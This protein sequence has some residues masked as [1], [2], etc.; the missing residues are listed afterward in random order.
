MDENFKLF[1][2]ALPAQAPRTYPSPSQLAQ[3]EGKL[4]RRL[5]DY[6]AEHGWGAFGRG[7]FWLVNPADYADLLQ[8]WCDNLVNTEDAYVIGRSAFG[9]LIVWKKGHG[10]FLQV[11]PLEHTIYTYAPHKHVKAGNENFS[12]AVFIGQIDLDMLDFEDESEKPLFKCAVKKLGVVGS[13]EMYA[14]EPAL[15]LGGPAQLASLVKVKLEEHL[16]FLA[17][18]G[19]TQV[20][21]IDTSR[22]VP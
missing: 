5:L 18:L 14:F 6:W 8:I 9:T 1:L 12:L 22:F 16:H 10:Q 2:D 17:E 3:F 13:D 7:L 21:H 15:S 20:I 19:E 11:E 4:P